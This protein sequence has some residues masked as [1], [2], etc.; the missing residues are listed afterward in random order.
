M[1]FNSR[2]KALRLA[3]DFTQ[4]ELAKRTGLSQSAIAM[5][6]NGKREPKIETLELL[7]DFFNV[8]MNYITGNSDKTTYVPVPAHTRSSYSQKEQATLSAAFQASNEFW[9]I[10]E[11]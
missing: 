1:P 4:G 2:L 6:E 5:Y 10:D 8:D 11:E 9:D 7:A 3:R